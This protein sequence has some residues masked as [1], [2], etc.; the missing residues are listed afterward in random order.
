MAFDSYKI[1]CTQN[2]SGLSHSKKI[3][4]T[5]SDSGYLR[6]LPPPPLQSRKL[7]YQLSPYHACAFYSMFY[8]YVKSTLLYSWNFF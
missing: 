2:E 7:V 6:K 1:K 3:T 5:L 4:L 8:T